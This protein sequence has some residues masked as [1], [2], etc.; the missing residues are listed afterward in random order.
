[1]KLSD[2]GLPVTPVPTTKPFVLDRKERLVRVPGAVIG[3]VRVATVQLVP[4]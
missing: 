1:M 3:G 2:V 4:S